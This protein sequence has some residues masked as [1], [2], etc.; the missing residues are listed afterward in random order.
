MVTTRAR[1]KAAAST[2]NLYEEATKELAT[3]AN[4]SEAPQWLRRPYIYS[5]YCYGGSIRR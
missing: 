4:V 2:Y 3:N 1:A 5:G